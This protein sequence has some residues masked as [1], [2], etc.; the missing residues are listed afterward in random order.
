MPK[1]EKALAAIWDHD[2]EEWFFRVRVGNRSEEGTTSGHDWTKDHSVP[3]E[4]LRTE[5]LTHAR[6]EGIDAET[7]PF[8]VFR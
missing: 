2:D 7:Y 1:Y 5:A 4:E 8:K 3:D 6:L